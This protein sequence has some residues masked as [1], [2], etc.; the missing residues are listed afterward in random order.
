MSFCVAKSSY[1]PICPEG[2]LKY[3]TNEKGDFQQ[4]KT[5][6]TIVTAG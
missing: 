2:R 1:F 3:F 6:V 5:G 4:M